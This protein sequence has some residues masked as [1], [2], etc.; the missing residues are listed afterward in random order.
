MTMFKGILKA[1]CFC[2][3]MASTT[4]ASGDQD[5]TRESIAVPDSHAPSSIYASVSAY[6]PHSAKAAYVAMAVYGEHIRLQGDP[7]ARGNAEFYKVKMRDKWLEATTFADGISYRDGWTEALVKTATKNLILTLS[8]GRIDGDE[9]AKLAVERGLDV[10]ATPEGEMPSS[11]NFIIAGNSILLQN[12]H[13]GTVLTDYFNKTAEKYLKDVNGRQPLENKPIVKKENRET[14]AERQLQK[15]GIDVEGL[16]KSAKDQKNFLKNMDKATGEKL[17]GIAGDLAAQLQKMQT[18]QEIKAQAELFAAKRAEAM[19]VFGIGMTVARLGGNPAAVALFDRGAGFVGQAMDTF[20]SGLT[21]AKNPA[22]FV[23]MYG[24]LGMA[25]VSFFSGPQQDPQMAAI[26]AALP[27]IMEQLRTIQNQIVELGQFMEK[28]FNNIDRTLQIFVHNATLHMHQISTSG[29]RTQEN[30]KFFKAALERLH[31]DTYG[32]YVL[33]SRLEWLGLKAKCF[34]EPTS[35]WLGR[36][37]FSQSDFEACRNEIGLYAIVGPPVT[38]SRE[39]SVGPDVMQSIIGR[40]KDDLTLGRLPVATQ[41]DPAAWLMAMNTMKRLGD[42]NPKYKSFLS[43]PVFDEDT[44]VTRANISRVGRYYQKLMREMA[45]ENVDS[46]R[47]SLRRRMIEEIM[48]DYKTA[49]SDSL[50]YVDGLPNKYFKNSPHPRL[51]LDDQIPD[52]NP[53]LYPFMAAPVVFCDPKGTIENWV[54]SSKPNVGIDHGFFKARAAVSTKNFMDNP[55]DITLPPMFLNDVPVAVKLAL[56]SAM[57]DPKYNSLSL[58]ACFRSIQLQDDVGPGYHHQTS[59]L[60]VQIDLVAAYMINGEIKQLPV[61]TLTAHKK[62]HSATVGIFHD[63]GKSWMYHLWNGIPL[64]GRPQG[65][66]VRLGP[67]MGIKQNWKDYFTSTTPGLDE[68]KQD[69]SNVIRE[70]VDHP[71]VKAI[72]GGEFPFNESTRK[73]REELAFVLERGL[74]NTH[75][76]VAEL[77]NWISNPANLPEADAWAR[78]QYS[79]GASPEQMKGVLKQRLD[80][81][82]GLRDEVSEVPNLAPGPDLFKSILEDFEVAT[83]IQKKKGWSAFD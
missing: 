26:M 46:K 71:I 65:S 3:L 47:P 82:N 69:F 37:G 5:F 70:N 59:L 68:F 34:A 67:A 4:D 15:H 8:K 81:L 48:E 10:L 52:A 80:I 1:L 83:S 36:S 30:E 51:N 53:N 20:G 6:Q 75:P 55:A 39:H 74:S 77:L 56:T 22:A 64:T 19:G 72:E 35:G 38:G 14:F 23:N 28:R 2:L 42:V 18:E 60:A 45:L 78:A 27:Q 12:M 29:M 24:A 43:L 11:T 16:K 44:E 9:L 61:V 33:S 17:K 7:T 32:S 21:F 13:N 41:P 63:P 49:V 25:A 50:L 54:T 79:A 58:A 73:A 76:A 31:T 57:A 66:P 62:L 40:L